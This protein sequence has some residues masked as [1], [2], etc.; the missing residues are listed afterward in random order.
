MDTPK[1]A[2]S[3]RSIRISKAAIFLLSEYKEWQD[4]Q[5]TMLGDAWEDID[6]RV[7]T[8]DFG[9]PIFPTSITQWFSKFVKRCGLPKVSVHSLRHT[10][11]SLMISDGVPLVAVSKQLGHA[12]TSTTANIYTH[13]IQATEARAAH[14]FDRFDDVIFPDKRQISG[15]PT[16]EASAG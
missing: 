15:N 1:T 13:V 7:F 11:A 8:N 3:A 6:G 4:R 14:T 2:K 5:R 9:A 10:C 12:Q 16:S